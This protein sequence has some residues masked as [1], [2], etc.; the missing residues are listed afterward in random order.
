MIRRW[1]ELRRSPESGSVLAIALVFML[2]FGIW[3]G[4][5]LQFAATDQRVGVSVSE[6]AAATYAAGGALDAA[7]NTV[8]GALTTGTSAAGTT[9]CFSLPAGSLDNST[10]LTVTCIPRA[11]SGA[12]AGG[13]SANQPDHAVLALSSI[14]A[15]GTTL[16]GGSALPVQGDVL[17]TSTLSVPTTATLTATGS[18]KAGTCSTAGTVSPACTTGGSPSDPGWAGPSTTSTPL[19]TTLP[20]CASQVALGPGVYRS[21][22]ALQ[23]V[24]NCASVVWFRPGTYFFDFRDAGSH[25]L[26]VP[27]GTDVVGGTPSGWTPGSTAPPYPN[28]TSPAASACDQARPGVDF[29]FG[30]DS[31]L[32]ANGGRLQLCALSTSAS[33]QHI[34][35]RD[36]GS[37]LPVST[38]GTAAATGSV[39]SSAAGAWAWDNDTQAAQVDGAVAHVKV[40]NTG[41]PPSRLTLSGFGAATVPADATGV[42]VTVTATQTVSGTG[43][44]TLGLVPGSGTA[45]PT[46]TLRDCTA[47]APCSA[48]G[49]DPSRSDAATFTGLTPAQVN[50]MRLDYMVTNPNNSPVEVWLDGVTVTLAYTLPVAATS[51]T[52]VATPYTSG[53]TSTTPLLLA[54]GAT[55]TLALH[56]TVYAPRSV[57]D[58]NLTAVPYTVIDR[59]VVVRHLRSSLT[60]AVGFTG[61][62]ISVPATGSAKR[63]ILLVVTDSA[64]AEQA[65]ADVTFADASGTGNG[66]IPTVN[67]WSV[68]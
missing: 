10:A 6:E 51:G 68:R 64:G 41:K 24:L 27:A 36:L 44:T 63:R 17:V 5:V 28:L 53:S 66:S 49:F 56:G 61:P 59:G 4:T 46:A 39:S 37:A 38:T 31:R 15:E 16:A 42:S 57:L 12:S 58:L 67:E 34:V 25:A 19:V 9:T 54:S 29:T 35:L 11:G 8:R 62:L 21:A 1:E 30:G 43:T 18:V 20:A 14:A 22:A 26:T 52:A 2:L 55:T 50:G 65:R 3:I 32:V 45:P 47:A 40:P 33:S 7:V 23:A 48:T 60:R 13:S